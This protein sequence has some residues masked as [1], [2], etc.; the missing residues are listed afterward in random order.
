MLACAEG[1]IDIARMLVG[2]YNANIDIQ[3]EVREIA[4]WSLCDDVG[5]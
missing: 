4:R 3:D 2:D 5:V 1:H